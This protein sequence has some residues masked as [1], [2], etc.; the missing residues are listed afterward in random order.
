MLLVYVQP[1][2][3]IDSVV[4]LTIDCNNGLTS[5][6]YIQISHYF[7]WCYFGW[8]AGL[9]S[10]IDRPVGYTFDG[11]WMI[12]PTAVLAKAQFAVDVGG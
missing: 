11:D 9:P 12:K 3:S 10:F 7:P 8:E 2:E 5:I 1:P 6:H 4:S